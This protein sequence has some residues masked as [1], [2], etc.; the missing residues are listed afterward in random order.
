MVEKVR[1]L[2]GTRLSAA[3]TMVD[4]LH[5]TSQ[6]PGHVILDLRGLTVVDPT[7]VEPGNPLPAK[8]VP[9]VPFGEISQTI[10]LR[11]LDFA[12]HSPEK[13]T[14]TVRCPH[15]NTELMIIG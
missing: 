13:K 15:C 1:S 4:Y 12:V 2:D 6:L 14:S 3:N 7:P 11:G 10:Y 9:E 5:K 8:A